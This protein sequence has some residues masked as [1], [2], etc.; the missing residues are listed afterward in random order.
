MKQ[1]DLRPYQS[2]LIDEATLRMT[3]GGHSGQGLFVGLGLG[4]TIMSLEIFK[5]LQAKRVVNRA[6]IVAPPRVCTLT[7]PDEIDRWEDYSD[8]SYANLSGLT[9]AK[10]KALLMERSDVCI[11][12]TDSV[13][14]LAKEFNTPGK[15]KRLPCDFLIVDESTAFKTWGSQRSKALR[16]LL[17]K[18]KR[19]LILTAT[20]RPNSVLD[21]FS[22]SYLIDRGATF[23][24]S[25][26]RF[27]SRFGYMGGFKGYVWTPHKESDD[28]VNAMLSP[29]VIRLDTADE[30]DMPELIYNDIEV[31]LPPK[32]R[33]QYRQLEREM[34]L[35]LSET[36]SITPI[37]AGVRYGACKQFTGGAV[38]RDTPTDDS[39]ELPTRE[40]ARVHDAKLNLL[41]ETLE[42]LQAPALVAY[43]YQW[44]HDAI[45][46]LLDKAKLEFASING[47]TKSKEAIGAVD[48]WNN[49]EL[50]VLLA[51]P[52]GVSHGVNLQ[53]GPGR[54]IIWFGLTDLPEVHVQFN[55]RIYR[56]GVGSCVTVHRLLVKSTVDQLVARRL[57]DKAAGEV[58]MLNYL[59]DEYKSRLSAK[60]QK[61][62]D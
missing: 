19:V 11:T 46:E 38:Y 20:P 30:I 53:Y 1:L 21:L 27:K 60:S 56:P 26:T 48:R 36:E 25:V 13:V 18:F 32:A 7:W 49:G 29:L 2:A 44:E 17:P 50:D 4:K 41:M 61:S 59:R 47:Q 51:Q 37:N 16:K 24:K 15:L 8:L 55:G 34:W 28:E 54:D 23:G 6:M 12:S 35:E 42:A 9:P 57:A 52:Q 31:D 3:E 62:S 45:G 39:G 22:Q 33:R 5:R 40:A 14:W 10:R 58:S 43:Q